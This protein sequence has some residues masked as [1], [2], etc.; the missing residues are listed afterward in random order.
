[1]RIRPLLL[2]GIFILAILFTLNSFT[3][4]KALPVED[5]GKKLFIR[6]CTVCHMTADPAGLTKEIWKNHVLPIMAA[7]MGLIYPGYDPLRGLSEEERAIV[8]KNHLIPDQPVIS[9][10]NWTKLVNYILKNA[11][12]SV[13]LD[14]KRLTRNAPLKQFVRED[15]QVDAQLPSLIT[16]L[17]YNTETN[18]LWI[19][20]FYNKVYNWQYDKGVTKTIETASPAVDFNFDQNRT[21]FMEIGKLY[22]TELS[23]GSYAAFENNQIQPIITALHRPVHT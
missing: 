22:P 7:R 3:V 20:N 12:D 6:Y 15:I 2:T 11:P 17:K 13:G 19:G 16:S 9:N 21:Y 4:K 23:T 18:T 5:E 1:M 8:N 14:E 10:E